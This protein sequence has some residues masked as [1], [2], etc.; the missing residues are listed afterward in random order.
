MGEV[1]VLE[2]PARQ[3]REGGLVIDGQRQRIELRPGLFLDPWRDQVEPGPGGL[4]GASPVS[5]C[6]GEQPHRGR[7]RHF[8]GGTGAGDR[9]Q[10][11]PRLGQI[12]EVGAHAVHRLGAERFDPRRLQRVEHRAGIAVDDGRARGV[13]FRVVVA[14]PQ[15]QRIGRAARLGHQPRFQRR[16]GRNDPRHLA[17]RLAAGV[18]R[19]HDFGLRIPRN[20][21]GRPGEHGA[22][23]VEGGRD[24]HLTSLDRAW[25][26][27]RRRRALCQ[28]PAYYTCSLR[29]GYSTTLLPSCAA[30]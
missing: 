20:R 13:Q 5:R 26:G 7:Q 12:A 10:P 16:S 18:R 2:Q 23:A 15:R 6:A 17:R 29:L 19:E 24:G 25:R 27:Q 4:G 9:V 8:L 3:C 14:Q 11:D 22:E 28:R 21:A 1:E 30:A